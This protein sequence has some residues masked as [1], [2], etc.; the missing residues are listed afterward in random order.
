MGTGSFPGVKR[1]ARDIDHPHHVA[2]RLKKEWSYTSTPPL[3]LRNLFQGELYFYLCHVRAINPTGSIC[4][5]KIIVVL[6]DED[7]NS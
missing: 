1:P 3:G 6:M 7:Y 4:F 5:E 2:P